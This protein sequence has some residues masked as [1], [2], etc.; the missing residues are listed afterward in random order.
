[1][2]EEKD[3]NLSINSEA[4]SSNK[5]LK[6][7]YENLKSEKEEIIMKDNALANTYTQ[8]CDELKTLETAKN[9]LV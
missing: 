9:L 8:F 7:E 4:S 2:S 3:G 1:M 6:Q 5:S